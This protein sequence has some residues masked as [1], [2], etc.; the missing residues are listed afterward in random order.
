MTNFFTGFGALYAGLRRRAGNGNTLPRRITRFA[1]FFVYNGFFAA[2]ITFS[3]LHA[4]LLR[5]ATS[6]AC[7][8][9][10]PL[11]ALRRRWSNRL[12]FTPFAGKPGLWRDVNAFLRFRITAGTIAQKSII[13]TCFFF[14]FIAI[15]IR[16]DAFLRTAAISWAGP[17]VC[18]IGTFY[19]FRFTR[20]TWMIP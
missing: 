4:F 20:M 6:R 9:M 19:Y 14:T 10:E 16:L 15:V 18:A 2:G 8:R 1:A 17:D 7:S 12:I 3:G 13:I 5:A 11:I